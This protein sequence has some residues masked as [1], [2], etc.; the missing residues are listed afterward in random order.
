MPEVG[1]PQFRSRCTYFSDAEKYMEALQGSV[2][3]SGHIPWKCKLFGGFFTRTGGD[4]YVPYGFQTNYTGRFTT[5]TAISIFEDHVIPRL[6]ISSGKPNG[7]W[8]VMVDGAGPF[9]DLFRSTLR[10]RYPIHFLQWPSMAADLAPMENVWGLGVGRI[11]R[12]ITGI[13]KW[14]EGVTRTVG[15]LREWHAFV[16]SQLKRVPAATK[17]K[18]GSTASMRGRMIACIAVEGQRIGR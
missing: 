2:P 12:A 7:P 8:T 10:A 15:H 13:K 11:G 3:R 9:G 16:I 4:L 5:T 17:K 14:R 1:A 18:L 6:R